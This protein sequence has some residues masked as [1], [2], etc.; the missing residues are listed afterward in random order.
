MRGAITLSSALPDLSGSLEIAGPGAAALTVARSPAPG[1]PEFRI[2]T[3]VAGAEV[4]ISG[5]TIAGGRG[6]EGG[7]IWN[8]GTLTVTRSNLTG[9]AAVSMAAA[10]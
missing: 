5:L 4:A 6:T 1:T 9:N 8:G 2:F 7:G 3:V 10:S